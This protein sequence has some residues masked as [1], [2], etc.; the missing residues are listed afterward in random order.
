[1][2]MLH[3][4]KSIFLTWRTR[5]NLIVMLVKISTLDYYMMYINAKWK[6]TLTI[7][8]DVNNVPVEI[9]GGVRID[10]H[11]LFSIHEEADILIT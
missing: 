10:W 11:D 3:P 9:A 6:H 5:F 4:R 1:M 7:I 2:D 8:T